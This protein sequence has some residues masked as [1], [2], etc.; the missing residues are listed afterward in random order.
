M[1]SITLPNSLTPS[2]HPYSVAL[3]SL[4][5]SPVCIYM[6]SVKALYACPMRV[7]YQHVLSGTA[8]VM[9]C[10]VDCA[11]VAS[12]WL[13]KRDDIAEL[14]HSMIAHSCHSAVAMSALQLPQVCHRR[15]TGALR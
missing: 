1:A 5:L 9:A 6:H 2:D 14:L 10:F 7:S 13:S 12:V 15:H 11:A 8:A 3:V 4:A